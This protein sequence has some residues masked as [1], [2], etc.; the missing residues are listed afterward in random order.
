M[1]LE[2]VVTVPRERGSGGCEAQPTALREGLGH[3]RD[4]VN[5]LEPTGEPEIKKQERQGRGEGKDS[6][7]KVVQGPGMAGPSLTSAAE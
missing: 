2:L 4:R 5:S 6:G 7:E 1:S 3:R